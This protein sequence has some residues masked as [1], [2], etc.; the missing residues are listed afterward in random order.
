METWLSTDYDEPAFEKMTDEEIVQ[1]IFQDLVSNIPTEPRMTMRLC[2]SHRP[3]AR[4]RNC[5]MM[6]RVPESATAGKVAHLR[7]HLHDGKSDARKR[8]TQRKMKDFFS[9]K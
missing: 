1:R 2:T 4:V 7:N 6:A 8:P 3:T 9:K 5:T